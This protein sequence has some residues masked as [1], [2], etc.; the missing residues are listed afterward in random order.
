MIQSYNMTL[1]VTCPP[2]RV[3]TRGPTLHPAPPL[4]LRDPWPSAFCRPFYL[5][6]NG[7]DSHTMLRMQQYRS[8]QEGSMHFSI[9][10]P[11]LNEEV[12]LEEQLA[13][14]TGQGAHHHC[15]LI[16]V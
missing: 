14:L 8:L 3:P 6:L 2:Y 13:Y 5:P 7:Q 4:P 10:V 15:E 9:I 11:V 16:I 12:V 1:R